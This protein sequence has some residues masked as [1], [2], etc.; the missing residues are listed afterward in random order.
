MI[1]TLNFIAFQEQ[2]DDLGNMGTTLIGSVNHD[3]CWIIDSRA[4]NH[5]T[6]DRTFFNSTTPSPQDSIVTT[7]G[8]IA[9]ITGVGSIA[10]TPMLS[11]Q[12]CLLVSTLSGHL[13][14]VGQVTE[15]LDCVVLMFTSF[16]LL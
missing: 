9:S 10:L 12:N 13:L 2:S 15:Q 6:Y 3:T 16:F 4:T 1:K 5:M 11:L 7:N 14:S 8:V